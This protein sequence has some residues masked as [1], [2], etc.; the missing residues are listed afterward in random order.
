MYFF[1]VTL[2]SCLCCVGWI[3]VKVCGE[4]SEFLL[5]RVVEFLELLGSCGEMRQGLC[6]LHML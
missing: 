2:D 4:G 6:R 1:D 3:G 5:G